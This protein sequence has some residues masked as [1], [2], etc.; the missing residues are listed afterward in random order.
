M[1]IRTRP[2]G[3]LPA[4][5]NWRRAI[6]LR[7]KAGKVTSAYCK[8]LGTEFRK[9]YFCDKAIYEPSIP[10]NQKS[11]GKRASEWILKALLQRRI[12]ARA[13]W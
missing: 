6:T 4:L 2:K 5:A 11:E 3:I 7:R 12:L 1:K 8:R 13:I 9:S 10:L